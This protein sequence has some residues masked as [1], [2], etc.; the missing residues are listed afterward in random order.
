MLTPLRFRHLWFILSEDNAGPGVVRYS[1][2]WEP[3][4]TYR[5]FGEGQIS[6]MR[7][8]RA[9]VPYG[10]TPSMARTCICSPSSPAG[11][12]CTTSGR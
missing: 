8:M 4:G 6:D 7:S 3:E 12:A 11:R 10:T 1:D 9:V 2:E 5:Y